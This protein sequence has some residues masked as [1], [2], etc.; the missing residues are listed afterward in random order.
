MICVVLS[1]EDKE[2]FLFLWF[3]LKSCAD[4]GDGEELTRDEEEGDARESDDED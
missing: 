4:N 1:L 2:S 3:A